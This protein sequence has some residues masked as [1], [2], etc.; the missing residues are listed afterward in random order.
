MT[1][2]PAVHTT[3]P[4]RVSMFGG[5]VKFADSEDTSLCRCCADSCSNS[6]TVTVTFCGITREYEVPIP[7]SFSEQFDL[8]GPGPG[9]S[10]LN[11][12]VLIGCTPCG[13]MLTIG[14]CAF[15]EETNQFVS[16]GFTALIPFAGYE[17]IEGGGDCPEAGPVDLICFGDQFGIPCVTVTTAVIG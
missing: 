2:L 5:L 3:E 14:I 7:G 8:D 9:Q 12:D 10:Y 15:C 13:W 11:V 16:E 17:E 1:K 4:L 6:V